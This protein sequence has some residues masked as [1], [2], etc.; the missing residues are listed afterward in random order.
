MN[1]S[2]LEIMT[3]L[4]SFP[5]VSRDSNLE[6][7]DWVE[8]YLTFHG[9]TSTRVP[10]DDGT[11]AAIYASIGPSVEG[12]V[13]LSGHTDVVPVDGQDWD[14]DPFTV[15]ERD[16]RYYGRGTCDMKGF[17]ALAL[18]AMAQAAKAEI[19][20]PLQIALSYDEEIGCTGAPPMIDH[21]VAN[22]NIPRAASAIIGEPST[23][24]AVTGHKTG[25]GFT[26]DVK[27][28]EVHSSLMHSGVS[29]ILESAHV[30]NWI[31]ETNIALRA[32]PA[33]DVAAMFEPPFTTVHSGVIS[34]GTA[35]NITAA[36]CSFTIDMRVVPDGDAAALEDGLRAIAGATQTRMQ[37]VHPD[38]GIEVTPFFYVPG[39][40]PESDGVA[41]ALVRSITGDNGSHV[42]SYGTEAGQF[43]ERGYSSV[44]CGPGDIAQ[45]HQPNEFIEIS[46]FNA[47]QGFMKSL[48]AKLSTE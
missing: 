47:G 29:A 15:T 21:M 28:F 31:N 26:V 48:I 22:T 11:K 4:I 1:L 41:E 32:A 25:I 30:L 9:I 17:D 39:L 46:E 24:Q 33:T 19:K 12:G 40:K 18:W 13:V 16:G 7:V 27:G 42:V 5:T 44:I 6:L 37:A 3:K 35:A 10:N 23:M 2:A 45:A 34:G 20:R 36:D 8:S 38:A 14:S 43:Q